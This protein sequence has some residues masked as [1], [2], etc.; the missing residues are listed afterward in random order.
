MNDIPNIKLPR[1]NNWYYENGYL[2]INLE[3]FGKYLCAIF[4]EFLEGYYYFQ[5]F[6]PAVETDKER[7]IWQQGHEMK[8]LAII[9]PILYDENSWD[10]YNRVRVVHMAYQHPQYLQPFTLHFKKFSSLFSKAPL[11][12]KEKEFLLYFGAHA[13]ENVN[14]S[15]GYIEDDKFIP[16]DSFKKTCSKSEIS[17]LNPEYPFVEEFIKSIF[18]YKILNKKPILDQRDMEIIIENFG[19]SKEKKLKTIVLLLENIKEESIKI[20]LENNSVGNSFKLKKRL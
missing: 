13:V 10:N 19:I 9:S 2:T 7:P 4:N 17:Y 12:L 6:T 3:L 8:N 14:I 20:I 15:L 5:K 11:Q 1:T 16:T 18:Y